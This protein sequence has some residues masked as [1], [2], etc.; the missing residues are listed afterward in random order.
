MTENGVAC[1]VLSA[2]CPAFQ[3]PKALSSVLVVDV[4]GSM[5]WGSQADP[6]IVLAQA[7][8]SSWVQGLPLGNSECAL[9]TFDGSNYFN[10]DFTT[11]RTKLLKAISALAPQGATDYDKALLLP[12]AGGLQVTKNAKYQRVIIML[13]DG[14]PNQE[15]QTAAIIAEAQ[16]QHCIIFAVTLGM[17]CPQNLKDISTQ[18][19]GTWF[20]N[21]TTVQDAKDVYNNILLQAQG[22]TPCTI[23]WQ[24]HVACASEQKA[25]Q[26]TWNGQTSALNYTAPAAPSVSLI[27]SPP[28]LFL[29]SKTPGVKFDT[30]IT[31]LC[32]SPTL[33][34]TN[35]TSSNPSFDINPK[36]FTLSSGSKQILTISYTPPDSN[37]NWT[38]FTFETGLCSFTYSSSG[39]FPGKKPSVQ[40][41]KIIQP[42]GGEIYVGGIDTTIIWTGVPASDKVKLEFSSDAGVTWNTITEQAS[43]GNYLWH[44]PNTPS[45]ACL[46]RATQISTNISAAWVQTV[47]ADASYIFDIALDNYGNTYAVTDYSG[48]ATIGGTPYKP[49]YPYGESAIIKY[50][51]DGSTEWVKT[52]DTAVSIR[53]I[54]VNNADNSIYIAGNYGGTEAIFDNTILP[55][56]NGAFFIAKLNPDATTAWAKGYDC[57]GFQNTSRVSVDASGNIYLA[58]QFGTTATFGSI[59]LT[60]SNGS[61]GESEFI[62]KFTSSGTPV[63]AIAFGQNQNGL[64]N[65]IAIAPSGAIYGTGTFTGIAQFGSST[66]TGYGND[67]YLIKLRQDGSIEWVNQLG[68]IR[69]TGELGE[70]ITID[71]SENIYIGGSFTGQAGF[72]K[73]TV[74]GYMSMYLAKYHSDGS[75]EWAKSFSGSNSESVISL[76]INPA[77]NLVVGGQFEGPAPF[78][79]DTLQSN[80][81]DLLVAELD[82][83]G[84]ALHAKGLGAVGYALGTFEPRG[85]LVDP[86]GNIYSCGDFGYSEDFNGIKLQ[87]HAKYPSIEEGFLWKVGA[88]ALQSDVSDAVFS[89]VVPQ[90]LS[91]NIDMGTV[92]V[93]ISKD[94]V[95]R[96]FVRNSGSFPF[97]V[98]SIVIS[99]NDASQFSIVSG[100]PPF[101]VA[102]SNSHQVEFRFLPSSVGS[103]S[104]Q[105]TIFAAG[106]TLHQTI[107]GIGTTVSIAV[108]GNIIDFGQVPIGSNKDT[109][110]TVALKNIGGATIDFTSASQLGP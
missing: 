48:I 33:T 108:M 82:P 109:T 12:A 99:G 55:K 88:G 100:F 16:N 36:S 53:A 70:A 79:S 63:W 4:S 17:P 92:L 64:N 1:T 54:T 95:I 56:T 101:E 2:D 83:K 31:L 81:Y 8:A 80:G 68:G 10:Q 25:V 96:S 74:S 6:N 28:S 110:V 50:H 40:T 29:P 30:S 90:P 26:I 43:G 14:M 5:A 59:T 57:S 20:E 107:I 51:S 69:S 45:N 18:T 78:G 37:Y 58:G 7:A 73:D 94:S 3:P 49:P 104:A 38:D 66:F 103:K 27:F 35:I 93:S 75:E 46:I 44:V 23:K 41:L 21:I 9:V 77:G 60:N 89:I 11:N 15:P 98:D 97:E 42:N 24:S 19:G 86:A 67:V 71:G 91:Q 87:S 106:D 32:Q 61:S 72:G 105:L 34:V 102:A 84:N 13:T 39:S 65:S 52:I 85:L 47:D 62:A 22:I 76:T